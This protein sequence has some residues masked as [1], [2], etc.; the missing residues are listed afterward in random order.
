MINNRHEQ[1]PVCGMN[2]D[3]EFPLEYHKMFFYFC[4][5]QCR[6]TFKEHPGLYSGKR[7]KEHGEVIKHRM[8]RLTKALDAETS[9]AVTECLR[10]LMGLKEL[11]LDGC[12]L[13]IRYDLLCVTLA[14]IE[15]ALNELGVTLDN[16]WWRRFRRGWIHN[17]EQN[18]LDNLASPPGACCNRPPPRV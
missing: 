7:A 15:Q 1:C 14:Q 16:G 18:E 11:Q 6:E 8:L 12:S 2:V 5:E 17:A 10:G 4:T 9:L 3:G 13:A